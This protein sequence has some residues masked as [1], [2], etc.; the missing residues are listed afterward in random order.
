MLVG[1]GKRGDQQR[2]RAQHEQQSASMS[3]PPLAEN[4]GHHFVGFM[5]DKELRA[6]KS[7]KPSLK[8]AVNPAPT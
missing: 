1:R 3:D 2:T 6:T 4:V 8:S 7:E 5:Y